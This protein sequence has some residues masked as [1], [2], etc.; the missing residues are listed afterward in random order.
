LVGETFSLD[1]VD[2][3][4]ELA[5]NANFGLTNVISIDAWIYLKD[6]VFYPAIV[7]KGNGGN[8]GESF[9]L[10]LY[11]GNQITFLVN[12]DGTCPGRV[13]VVGSPVPLNTW[14]HVA[15]TYCTRYL[16]MS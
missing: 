16:F 8:C 12:T 1:G 6:N 11:E 14:T 5:S 13:Y 4:V 15:G 3:Y 7:S 2:D 9:H 10:Y